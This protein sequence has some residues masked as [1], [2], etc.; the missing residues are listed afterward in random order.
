MTMHNPVMATTRS[1]WKLDPNHTLVEFSAKHMMFTTVKGHF[2]NVNGTIVLDEA[3][4]SGSSLE[5]EIDASSLDSGVEYRDNHLKS[6]DFLDVQNYPIMT[7]KS[8]CIEL[9]NQ[10]H[11]RVIGNLTIRGVTPT[12]PVSIY[13]ETAPWSSV[14]IA[15]QETLP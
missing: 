4:P 5:V 3:D 8:T 12:T 9:E 1:I 10:D 15:W 14:K 2:K 6:P 13:H 7:F 11:G